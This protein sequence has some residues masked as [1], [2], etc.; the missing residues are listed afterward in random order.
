MDGPFWAPKAKCPIHSTGQLSV[1]GIVASDEFTRK[2][3]ERALPLVWQW[4]HN[5]D[6]SLWP[7]TARKG[8]LRLTTGRIDTDFVMARNSLTQRTIGPVCSGT[9][10]LDISNMKDGD[11]AG[12]GLLQKNYGLA[13]VKIIGDSKAI[14]MI[15]A[16]TGKPVETQKIPLNQKVLSV[17]ENAQI[18]FRISKAQFYR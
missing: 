14:I 18:K 15:N 2:K 11:F 6:N 12:L 17:K 9:V 5:P 4:N 10:S 3:G 16:S 8:Y 13:G 7:V 1:S